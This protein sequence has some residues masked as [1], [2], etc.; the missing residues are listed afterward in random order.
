MDKLISTVV[1]VLVVSVCVVGFVGLMQL[2]QATAQNIQTIIL[3]L[4]K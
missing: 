3:D 2:E 4:N 1:A